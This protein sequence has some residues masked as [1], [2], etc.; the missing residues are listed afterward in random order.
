[1]S[2]N[3]RKDAEALAVNENLGLVHAVLDVADA[4]REAAAPFQA[5]SV[6]PP[7]ECR[8][9]VLRVV[10]TTRRSIRRNEARRVLD[11]LTDPDQLLP[12]PETLAAAVDALRDLIAE[13]DEINQKEFER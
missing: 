9:G 12:S 11:A 5:V 8:I 6:D 7:R 10:G 13:I 3:H 1:M 4:I 2:S